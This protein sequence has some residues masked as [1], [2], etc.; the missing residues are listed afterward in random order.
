MVKKLINFL[1]ILQIIIAIVMYFTIAYLFET[2]KIFTRIL[3]HTDFEATILRLLIY[4]IPG[5]NL[6]SGFFGLV[7]NTTKLKIFIALLEILAGYL[8]IY[9]QGKSEFMYIMGIVMIVIGGVIIVATL[10]DRLII[11]LKKRKK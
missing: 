6:I 1:S 5:I 8:A 2:D 7:F 4:I 3:A 10:I 11:F 9:Y